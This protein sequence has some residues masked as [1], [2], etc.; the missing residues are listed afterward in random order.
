MKKK[1]YPYSELIKR[2]SV[3]DSIFMDPVNV[4]SMLLAEEWNAL[5]SGLAWPISCAHVFEEI[6]REMKLQLIRAKRDGQPSLPTVDEILACSVVHP[7][8]VF[9][10]TVALR[11]R[12]IEEK[13]G[14]E[15]CWRV[16]MVI[17]LELMTDDAFALWWAWQQAD[18][19]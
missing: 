14:V 17:G 16:R 6:S 7:P 18:D 8:N 10:E 3:F 12:D 2:L 11:I 13:V 1:T 19:Y 15:T 4:S 5:M 9:L